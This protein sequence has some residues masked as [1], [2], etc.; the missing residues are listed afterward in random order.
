M[1]IHN[2][3][4]SYLYVLFNYEKTLADENQSEFVP[5]RVPF[6]QRETELEGGS[7][8]LSMSLLNNLLR[9]IINLSVSYRWSFWNFSFVA[10]FV[11]VVVESEGWTSGELLSFM[12]NVPSNTSLAITTMLFIQTIVTHCNNCEVT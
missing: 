8:T 1:S 10:S 4:Y 9:C 5:D 2:S 11:K 7:Y 3:W 12:I 6:I